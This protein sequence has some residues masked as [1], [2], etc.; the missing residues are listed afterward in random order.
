MKKHELDHWYNV[1]VK[2][3]GCVNSQPRTYTD[4]NAVAADL[5]NVS[6]FLNRLTIELEKQEQADRNPPPEETPPA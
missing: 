3:V 5:L 4:W 6:A 1:I 2:V